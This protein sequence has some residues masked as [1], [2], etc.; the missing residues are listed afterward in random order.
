M[1]RKNTQKKPKSNQ[2]IIQ[3]H[4]ILHI[5]RVT[6]PI[7]STEYL[8]LCVYFS[9]AQKKPTKQKKIG[10]QCVEASPFAA[11]FYCD[12]GKRFTFCVFI[13]EFMIN[14]HTIIYWWIF[15]GW[16]VQPATIWASRGTN[17]LALSSPAVFFS[18]FLIAS[19]STVFR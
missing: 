7:V 11:P 10:Q 15:N 17:R 18:V 6:K 16:I 5:I 8:H 19:A 2:L 14:S 4:G 1:Q 13:L 12:S 3:F 9:L